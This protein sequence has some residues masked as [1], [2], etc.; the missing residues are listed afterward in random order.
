MRDEWIARFV[1]RLLA[2]RIE[3]YLDIW[4]YEKSVLGKGL[5]QKWLS[6][7]IV[8]GQIPTKSL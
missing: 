3:G 8:N 6:T 1:A 4:M 2:G 5:K 7:Q